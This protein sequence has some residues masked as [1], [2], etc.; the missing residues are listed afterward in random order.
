MTR[1]MKHVL[2]AV[3]LALAAFAF[4]APSFAA[5][6]EVK[7]LNKSTDGLFAFAPD[8]VSIKPGDTVSFVAT[9]KGHDVQSIA[10]MLPAGA[11]PFKTQLSQDSKVTFTTPGVYVYQCQPHLGL[12][13][14][15][16]VVVGSAGNLDQ[17]DPSKLP[18][19]AQ[20]RLSALL[21]QVKTSTAS[22]H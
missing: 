14:V 8:V 20:K 12:G 5:E 7:E 13:M 22:A 10:G 17:I 11:Q 19:L 6:V 16:V 3:G 9:D 2:G 4:T 21:Q 15:G 18:P 1:T